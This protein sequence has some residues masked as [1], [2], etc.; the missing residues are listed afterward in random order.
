MLIFSN[1]LRG[2]CRHKFAPLKTQLMDNFAFLFLFHQLHDKMLLGEAVK[3]LTP[4]YGEWSA[5]VKN[6]FTKNICDKKVYSQNVVEKGLVSI[7]R[8]KVGFEQKSTY[9]HKPSVGIFMPSILDFHFLQ[10][11]NNVRLM[12]MIWKFEIVKIV[13]FCCFFTCRQTRAWFIISKTLF[14]KHTHYS[15]E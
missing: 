2:G 1:I 13:F 3:S 8:E 14:E 5:S 10:F 4:R 11:F 15:V 7:I 9:G 6:N 12:S